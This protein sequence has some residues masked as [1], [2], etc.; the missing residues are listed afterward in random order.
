M[1]LYLLTP[2]NGGNKAA[3]TR[4]RHHLLAG[5]VC[6]MALGFATPL[7]AENSAVLRFDTPLA[8]TDNADFDRD[9]PLEPDSSSFILLD[10]SSLSSDSG[11][12]WALVSLRNDAGG[13]RILRDDYLV[14][15]FANGDRRHASNLEGSFAAAEQQRKMVFFGYHRFPI[16]RVF[17]QQ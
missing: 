9:N 10:A 12:R 7:H 13:Q 3:N 4:Q 1:R 2:R 11:E 5:A 17:T 14:A 8:I 16:L 6:A 15:E